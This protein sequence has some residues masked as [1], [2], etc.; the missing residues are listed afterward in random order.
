VRW[1]LANAAWRAAVT[2]DEHRRF[3]SAYYRTRA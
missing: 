1:Y 2:S 3:Q